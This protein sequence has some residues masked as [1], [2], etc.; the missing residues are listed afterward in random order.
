MNKESEA[1]FASEKSTKLTYSVY[2]LI[3]EQF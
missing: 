3:Y 1:V 2:A